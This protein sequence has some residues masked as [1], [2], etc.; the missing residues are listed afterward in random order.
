MYYT[1]PVD[2]DCEVNMAMCNEPTKQCIS[3]TTRYRI[4]KEDDH[5]ISQ[6]V[7]NYEAKDSNTQ[8][9]IM[10]YDETRT[11][12]ADSSATPITD[13]TLLHNKL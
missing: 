9:S 4:R 6:S 8:L 10:E 5:S 13:I 12:E 3:R 11:A 7:S 1:V 2:E